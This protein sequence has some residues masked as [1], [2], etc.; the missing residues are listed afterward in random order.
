MVKFILRIWVSAFLL[1]IF[2]ASHAFSCDCLTLRELLS[3]VSERIVGGITVPL[4]GV[5][6]EA[7]AY[8]TTSLHKDLVAL[9]EAVLLSKESISAS[10]MAA[11]KNAAERDVEKT[12][13]AGSQPET[14][15]GL[16]EAGAGY[17]IGIKTL[18]IALDDIMEKLNGRGERYKRPLDY[19]EELRSDAFPGPDR[20]SFLL[21]TT[22]GEATLSLEETGDLTRLIESLTDPAPLPNLADELKN[23]PSGKIFETA[24]KDYLIRKALYQGIVVKK[25][26]KRA[27]VIEG[28]SL[29]A[30]EKWASMGG[31]GEAPYLRDG[32]LSEEAFFWYLSNMRLAS[33]NWH[34]EVLPTLPEAGLLR[35][36]VS[37]QAVELELI[38]RQSESLE[39]LALILSLS[40]LSDLDKGQRE[41]VRLQY[42][43]AAAQ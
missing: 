34:E 5:I 28:L 14:S 25:A 12:Y 9:R 42:D 38:R 20:V 27:P 6:R 23:T 13:E 29:W 41:A 32:K 1:P 33:A 2:F 15:C 4:D 40:A 39:N 17:Q 8:G 37:M 7:A 19:Q 36:L 26:S 24:K 35:E 43:R 22:G 21:G 3:G 11:D 16:G 10:V 31:E 18:E 30:E